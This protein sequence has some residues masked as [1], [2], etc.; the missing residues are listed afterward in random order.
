[1]ANFIEEFSGSE[2][3]EVTEDE[4]EFELEL[5]LLSTV[6][7]VVVVEDGVLIG[8]SWPFITEYPSGTSLPYL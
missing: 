2:V 5:P 1:M 6:V 7:D 3:D 4:I 8:H